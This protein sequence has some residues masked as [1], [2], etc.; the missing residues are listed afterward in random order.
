MILN[1]VSRLNKKITSILNLYE[2]LHEA[3]KLISDK[4]AYYNVCIFLSDS[5]GKELKLLAAT[6]PVFRELENKIRIE[7][8]SHGII[9]YVAS[10]GEPIVVPDVK[11]D[12]RYFKFFEDME[13]KSELAVPIKLKNR[14]IGVLDVQSLKL[15]AFV[16]DD[17][18]ALQILAE[19][20]SIEKN[21]PA[22]HL[23]CFQ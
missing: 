2:L 1:L 17:V 19:Q 21:E 15:D 6:R 11:K 16:K 9:S 7:I 4:F 13:T 18:L 5:K 12:A 14:V 3:T 10:I 22:M 23:N 20:L 8:G